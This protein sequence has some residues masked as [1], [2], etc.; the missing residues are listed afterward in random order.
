VLDP[1][2]GRITLVPRVKLVLSGN[3][4]LRVDDSRLADL[5]GRGVDG[6]RDGKPGG[7]ARFTLR[8]SLTRV[9]ADAKLS[10]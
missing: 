5:H 3:F 4:Q 2:T 7:E 9:Q 1:V 6:D 10:P 8:K